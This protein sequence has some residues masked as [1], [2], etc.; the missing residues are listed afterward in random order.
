MRT[1]TAENSCNMSKH[2]QNDPEEIIQP[3]EN[4]EKEFSG[5]FEDPDFDFLFAEVEKAS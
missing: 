1:E 5:Q 2:Y 3:S 4:R